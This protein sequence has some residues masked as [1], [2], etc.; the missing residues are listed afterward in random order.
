MILDPNDLVVNDGRPQFDG[1]KNARKLF[2]DN[3]L[4]EIQSC[5]TDAHRRTLLIE[6]LIDQEETYLS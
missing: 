6:K 5:G 1:D 2:R 3:I 4:K